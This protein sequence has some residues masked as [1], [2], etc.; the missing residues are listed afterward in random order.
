MSNGEPLGRPEARL[1]QPVTACA[2]DSLSAAIDR[3]T[4]RIAALEA[5]IP[6]P[7]DLSE[8]A[9][10]IGEFSVDPRVDARLCS[11]EGEL[12]SQ[13]DYFGSNWQ[14]WRP[15]S[16][17]PPSPEEV[18]AALESVAAS[19]RSL[20]NVHAEFGNDPAVL[21]E[22]LEGLGRA[23]D[24]FSDLLG[25]LADADPGPLQ[26]T[27]GEAGIAHYATRQEAEVPK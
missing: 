8:I 9:C 17:P 1:Y 27:V 11:I 19:A 7:V 21:G 16:G 5:K 23:L 10:T 3:L 4:T 6:D 20:A 13:A 25:R 12:L 18:G 22:Y 15:P 2:P 24:L 14:P 26:N